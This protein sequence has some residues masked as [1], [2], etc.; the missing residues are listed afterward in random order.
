MNSTPSD[1]IADQIRASRARLDI[2]R[3]QLAARCAALGAPG[4]T[5]AAITNIETGRREKTTKKRRRDV[6][7]DELM[8]L[9][10]ALEVPPALLV[11]PIGSRK[12]EEI[13]FLPGTKAPLWPVLRWFTGEGRVPVDN[14][15]PGGDVDEAGRPEWY[16]DPE[17]GWEAGAAPLTLRRQHDEQVQ[18]WFRAPTVVRDMGLSETESY[19]SLD[20]LRARIADELRATRTEMRRLGLAPPKLYEE[21]EHI[22]E[23]PAGRRP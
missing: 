6:T 21:L 12:H 20:R 18:S 14:L 16:D 13:E 3:D 19:A 8:V 5:Y 17:R 9:A 11:L 10:R 23:P 4:L 15:I 22:D 2:T 7:V 1:V